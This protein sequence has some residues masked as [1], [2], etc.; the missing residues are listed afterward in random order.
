MRPAAWADGRA[1]DGPLARQEGGDLLRRHLICSR[2]LIEGARRAAYDSGRRRTRLPQARHRGAD[3]LA[4]VLG[5]QHRSVAR[6]LE[7]LAHE[8]V[9]A[10]EAQLDDDRAVAA[11]LNHAPRL[12]RPARALGGDPHA[13]AARRRHLAGAQPAVDLRR[14]V[15]LRARLE[16]SRRSPS[17][18]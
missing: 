15:H 17:R 7:D 9:D 18:A 8:P 1:G 5:L 3:R 2:R 12:A 4:R 13:C 6:F 10:G 16:A 11:L 14:R